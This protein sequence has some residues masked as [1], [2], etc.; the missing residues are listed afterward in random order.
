MTLLCL[1]NAQGR[2]EEVQIENS[3]RVEFEKPALEAIRK[4]RFRPGV[5]DGKDVA[6]Y[7]RCPIAF[8]VN[9]K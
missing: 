6:T 8:R 5:K 1:V 3:S 7:L 2:V 9:S 4:W